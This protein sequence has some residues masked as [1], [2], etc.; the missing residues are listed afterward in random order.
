MSQ[1]SKE[2]NSVERILFIYRDRNE[3]HAYALQILKGIVKGG[4][5]I[6]ISSFEETE[7]IRKSLMT[8]DKEVSEME[9]HGILK[10]VGSESAANYLEDLL[11]IEETEKRDFVPEGS[12]IYLDV[13]YKCMKLYEEKLRE[14]PHLNI[15]LVLGYELGRM[16]EID[17]ESFSRIVKVQDSLLLSFKDGMEAFVEGVESV[18]CNIFGSVACKTIFDILEQRYHIKRESI[19]E[20]FKAFREALTGLIGKGELIT[21]K[22]I[23]EELLT[24]TRGN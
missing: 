5:G 2:G 3:G 13:G 9:E 8:L 1:S 21:E 10:I 4:L 15:T 16:K 24:R 6:Y 20:E 7:K 11:R 18:M 23:I 12:R 17:I 19:P 22:M 14:T